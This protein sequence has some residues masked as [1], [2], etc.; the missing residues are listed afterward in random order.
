[1]SVE[2]LTYSDVVEDP[3]RRDAFASTTIKYGT[4]DYGGDISSFEIRPA[5]ES[6]VPRKR[7]ATEKTVRRLE[8]F[9]VEDR[10]EEYKVAFVE[11]GDHLTFY[12]LPARQLRRAGIIAPNQPFQMDEVEIQLDGARLMT[13][14]VFCPLAS[15]SDSFIDAI[16]LNEDRSRKFS[17]IVKKFGK[18][19]A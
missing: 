19:K 1:M 6:K 5:L 13:G 3:K 8:G 2:I 4:R 17:A 16:D 15:P 7:E 12:Y 9:L 10:G 11:N 14:Y 18:P